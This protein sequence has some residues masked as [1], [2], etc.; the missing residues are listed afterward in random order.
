[1]GYMKRIVLTLF[2]VVL[3]VGCQE[4]MD[5]IGVEKDEEDPVSDFDKMPKLSA[6]VGDLSIQTL[7]AK[8]NWDGVISTI[9]I[10]SAYMDIVSSVEMPMI[11]QG[12]IIELHFESLVPKTIE[13]KEILRDSNGERKYNYRSDVIIELMF[14]EE[15]F[16]YFTVVDN[17]AV[18]LSS[19]SED[20][21][22][23]NIYKG[24]EITCKWEDGRYEGVY[25]FTIHP[26][27]GSELF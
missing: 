23:E 4:N 3:M 1:M 17:M 9:D 8:T 27:S 18:M 25:G 12:E 10:L 21:K 14:D 22:A 6:N 19:N 24:Y 16:Y 13:V 20:Y 2:L 7:E 15:G 26:D 5:E 11:P